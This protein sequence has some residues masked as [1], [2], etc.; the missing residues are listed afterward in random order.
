MP[1]H[2]PWRK[3]AIWLQGHRSIW[4]S[5]TRPDGRPHCVP[6][7]RHHNYDYKF[8][9]SVGTAFM[10]PPLPISLCDSKQK[11]EAHTHLRN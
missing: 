4:L 8:Q 5:T 10:L 3:V 11:T 9:C 6:T 2:I 7:A 1:G